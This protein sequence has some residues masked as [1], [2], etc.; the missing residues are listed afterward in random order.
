MI[1]MLFHYDFP[2]RKCILISKLE[3]ES[4]NNTKKRFMNIVTMI[5]FSVTEWYWIK[6]YI[7]VIVFFVL[8]F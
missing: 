7:C 6:S 3:M 1:E 4:Y 2:N 5:K 8:F